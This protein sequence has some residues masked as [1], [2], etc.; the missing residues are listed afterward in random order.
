[1]V[2]PGLGKGDR[3]G[4]LAGNCAE[5]VEVELAAAKAGTIC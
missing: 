3:V 1:M 4:L 5:Y 2:N